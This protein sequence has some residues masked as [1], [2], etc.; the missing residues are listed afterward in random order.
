LARSFWY[1]GF[2]PY[3][4]SLFYNYFN[5]DPRRTA[6]WTVCS[7]AGFLGGF[8]A[9]VISNPID[10][11]YNRQVADALYP[12]HLQRGY[13]S[14]IDGLLK[15]HAEGA[16]FRGSV[17]SGFALGMMNGGMSN[18]YDWTKEY[19]YW[20]FGPAHWL[21]PV[22]LAPTVYL[23]V[24]LY[25]PFDNIRVR[26]HTMTPLPNG[27]MPYSGFLDCIQKILKYEASLQKY[28]SPIAMLSGGVPAFWRMFISF[29]IG[30]NLTDI[31][32]RYNYMEGD[33]W[34]PSTVYQ[35]PRQGYI[36][37]EPNHIDQYDAK[38]F[39]PIKPQVKPERN[40]SL[41][42]GTNSYIKY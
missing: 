14:F 37:H 41:G 35:G 32:F 7:F 28:S 30:V 12:K 4:W 19:L 9:G 16:L 20:I 22:L 36:P 21:R 17:A 10:L 24:C 26:F 33:I 25:L 42:P 5:R 3:F 38:R 39:S 2:R 40:I 1:G 13:T 15:V 6:H 11:V 29:Y 34:E 18:F 23:G 8:C 27:E 31:A